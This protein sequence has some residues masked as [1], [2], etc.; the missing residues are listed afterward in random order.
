MIADPL[1]RP[2]FIKRTRLHIYLLVYSDNMATI[3]YPSYDKAF[4]QLL[5]DG[6]TSEPPFSRFPLTFC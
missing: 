6:W 1:F 4:S 2:G 3:A 5:M